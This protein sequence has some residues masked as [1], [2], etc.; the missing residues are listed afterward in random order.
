MEHNTNSTAGARQLPAATDYAPQPPLSGRNTTGTKRDFESTFPHSAPDQAAK[1]FRSH[2]PVRPTASQYENTDEALERN[3]LAIEDTVNNTATA[4]Q[5]C[6]MGNVTSNVNDVECLLEGLRDD[7]RKHI[8]IIKQNRPNSQIDHETIRMFMKETMNFMAAND[9]ATPEDVATMRCI[10]SPSDGALISQVKL[11]FDQAASQ[12]SSSPLSEPVSLS[13][14]PSSRLAAAVIPTTISAG[15]QNKSTQTE[16]PPVNAHNDTPDAPVAHHHGFSHTELWK[17]ELESIRRF[18]PL[19]TGTYTTVNVPLRE[20]IARLAPSSQRVAA[21]I[22]HDVKS[23]RNPI[24]KSKSTSGPSL[25]P[26]AVPNRNY[27]QE[28]YDVIC[29]LESSDD[30]SKG[31]LRNSSRL[32]GGGDFIYAEHGADCVPS[33]RGRRSRY[34]GR[35]NMDSDTVD[36]LDDYEEREIDDTN[37]EEAA[38]YSDQPVASTGPYDDNDTIHDKYDD[39]DYQDYQ[40]EPHIS[41]YI[42]VM[43]VSSSEKQGHAS[44][45]L[46]TGS[47]TRNTAGRERSRAPQYEQARVSDNIPYREKRYYSR[48][49]TRDNLPT[50]AHRGELY[51]A[52]YIDAEDHSL[53]RVRQE[54]SHSHA[55]QR[56]IRDEPENPSFYGY[57]AKARSA[58]EAERALRYQDRFNDVGETPGPK[59]SLRLKLDKYVRDAGSDVVCLE[60]DIKRVTQETFYAGETLDEERALQEGWANQKTKLYKGFP[61]VEEI[62]FVTLENKANPDGDCYWR[63]LAYTLHGKPTR[64]DVIKADHYIYMQHVLSDK[65]HPRHQLYVKLNTQFFD[66]QG[67]VQ[68]TPPFKANIW[69]LLHLPHSWTP[70]VMQQITADLYNIHLVTFTHDLAKNMCSEV[71]LSTTDGQRVPELGVPVPTCDSG[72]DGT[73]FECAKAGF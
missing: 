71:P 57:S 1:R 22:S 56:Y 67:G 23:N 40:S 34:K 46:D 14:P 26:S 28:D 72:R 8:E 12:T 7:I 13:P 41:N 9:L 73:L 36:D 63:A 2:S 6:E 25:R 44:N 10:F 62:G 27:V 51:D 60:R 39:A 38:I 43:G 48:G 61:L 4:G 3:S 17:R 65:T 18:Q 45:K 35:Y 42:G 47:Y 19:V 64:W 32:V 11:E 69:Q 21:S 5:S 58:N 24:R 49:Y 37:Q 53:V 31:V 70:G 16:S 29:L 15:L 68:G 50:R 54:N 33:D 52:K 66:T 30:E 55:G 59:S 20:T